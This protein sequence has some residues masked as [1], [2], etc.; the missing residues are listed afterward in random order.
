MQN[1][2]VND[3][4]AEKSPR[5]IEEQEVGIVP[6]TLEY[7]N[8]R[9]FLLWNLA[10]DNG[11]R[12]GPFIDMTRKHVENEGEA[13]ESVSYCVPIFH[14]KTDVHGPAQVVFTSALYKWCEIF[15]NV[16]TACPN[17]TKVHS[18]LQIMET[19]W[20]QEIFLVE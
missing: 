14:H 19:K 17:V 12:S 4:V 13:N 20:H 10:V 5:F 15:L 6:K 18:L 9:D 1:H 3:S 2:A 8:V 16:F 7:T 11:G